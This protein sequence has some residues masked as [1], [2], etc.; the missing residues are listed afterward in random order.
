VLYLDSSATLKLVRE[1]D[2]SAALAAFLESEDDALLTSRVGAVE[3]RR[4]ARRGGASP[5]R[6]DALAGTLEIVELNGVIEGIAVNV[7]ADLRALD[8]MHLASALALEGL[9]GFVCYDQ[10]LATAAA[11]AGLRVL[12]PADEL[13]GRSARSEPCGVHAA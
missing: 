9:R 10:R 13:P 3:L 4:V 6:A 5:D 11:S 2:E 12:A 1:E 8:A 7:A